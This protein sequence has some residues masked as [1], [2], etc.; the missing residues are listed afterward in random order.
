M[1]RIRAAAH[2]LNREIRFDA[3][4]VGVLEAGRIPDLGGALR[5]LGNAGVDPI[6]RRDL[7]REG[8]IALEIFREDRILLLAYLVLSGPEPFLLSSARTASESRL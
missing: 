7:A 8:G 6:A 5:D 1:R 3:A 4:V 2:L